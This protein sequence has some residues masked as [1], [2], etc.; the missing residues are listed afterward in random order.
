LKKLKAHAGCAILPAFFIIILSFLTSFYNYSFMIQIEVS[1]QHIQEYNL[2]YKEI[3]DYVDNAALPNIIKHCK[4]LSG[5]GSRVSGYLGSY[6]AAHYIFNTLKAYG[7]SDVHFESFNVTVPIDYGAEITVLQPV[8]VSFNAYTVWPNDVATGTTPPEGLVGRL[9]YGGEGYLTDFDGKDLNGSIVLMEFNSMHNWINAVKLGAKGI[10]FILPKETTGIE[11]ST[12]FADVPISIPRVVVRWNDGIYLRELAKQGNPIVKL[13]VKMVWEWRTIYNI[14]GTIPGTT[15][16]EEKMYILSNYDSMSYVPALSPGASEA[17]GVSALLEFASFIK[18]HPPKYTVIFIATGASNHALL[19]A[20]EYVYRHKKDL[21][22]SRIAID[23]HFDTG[24]NELSFTTTGLQG[25]SGLTTFHGWWSNPSPFGEDV[26]RRIFGESSY[27]ADRQI[28]PT[29]GYLRELEDEVGRFYHVYSFIGGEGK[30]YRYMGVGLAESDPFAWVNAVNSKLTIQTI[31]S[32]WLQYR[33]PTDTFEKLNFE[34][35]KPQIEVTFSMLKRLLDDDYWHTLP[36]QKPEGFTITTIRTLKYDREEGWYKPVPHAIVHAYPV[37]GTVR[38][39]AAEAPATPST[40]RIWGFEYYLIT[41]DNGEATIRCH[42]PK[43]PTVTWVA[44]PFIFKAYLINSTGHIIAATD[45]GRYGTQ[46]FPLS[47]ALEFSENYQNIILFECGSIVS[48]DLYDPEELRPYRED[49]SITPLQPQLTYAKGIRINVYDFNTHTEPESYSYAFDTLKGILWVAVPPNL[50]TEIIINTETDPYPVMFLI[51]ADEE[52]SSGMGY[53]VKKGDLLSIT[54]TPLIALKN[55]YLRINRIIET[56]RYHYIFTPTLNFYYEK[57]V[58]CY[59]KALEASNKKLYSISYVEAYKAWN[60]MKRAYFESRNLY[61]GVMQTAILTFI[62]IIPFAFLIERLI[63]NASGKKRILAT[64]LM[65]VIPF[66]V[67]FNIH[68]AFLLA[69]NTVMTVFATIILVLSIPLF[70]IFWAELS[71]LLKNLRKEI[72]GPHLA[73]ISRVGAIVMAFSYGIGQMRKHKF[74][75]ILNLAVITIITFSFVSIS[76]LQLVSKTSYSKIEMPSIRN[77]LLIEKQQ[78]F[79]ISPKIRLL[80][81]SQYPNETDILF[82]SWS[83]GET[84]WGFN[85][86]KIISQSGKTTQIKAILGLQ[87]EEMDTLRNWLLIEDGRFFVPREGN[88]ILLSNIIA[89]E[90]GVKT[91]DSVMLRG[92]NFTVVGIFNRDS[93]NAMIDL[94]GSQIT[95]IDPTDPTRT[96]HYSATFIAIIPF[97]TSLRLPIEAK[98]HQIVVNVQNPNIVW[99]LASSLA[100]LFHLEIYAQVNGETRHYS[101]RYVYTLLGWESMIVPYVLSLLIIVNTLINNVITRTRDISILNIVGLSP[102]HIA[103]MFFAESMVYA[104]I[105]SMLGYIAG[106]LGINI[107]Y[108]FQI[109]PA[110]FSANYASTTV[111]F[112]IALA[113][114]TTLGSTIYP[115]FKASRLVTP[116]LERSWKIPTKPY[117]NSWTIPLPFKSTKEECSGIFSFIHEYLDVFKAEGGPFLVKDLS[118]SKEDKTLKLDML[119]RLPPFEAGCDQKATL[120]AAWNEESSV[121]TFGVYLQRLSGDKRTWIKGNRIFINEL[122]KQFLTWRSLKDHRK[123]GL[124]QERSNEKK[125]K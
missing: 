100:K 11:A 34:N 5:L 16:P 3:V 80:I 114:I 99:D 10:I 57:A 64:V 15:Y 41:N 65:F 33:S 27:D 67:V 106:I 25:A 109:V 24:S 78:Y 44:P 94:D 9:I 91:G 102:L 18:S 95:P 52:H 12:K 82:R 89:E 58:Q 92:N 122:R 32:Y 66:V 72:I 87:P 51:N 17:L 30:I 123:N 113:T 50:D 28:K 74:T 76:S 90:L 53:K 2:S 39:E 107:Y 23:L 1:P 120:I 115:S 83:Y 45:F 37:A 61:T 79:S 47:N 70:F 38:P 116:S 108:S 26:N 29:G 96:I 105:G 103:A 62:L 55:I 59:M 97:D 93:L 6:L 68:P 98:I 117:G 85:P 21:E 111:I 60:Y 4:F 75:T 71:N 73:E 81:E 20:R 46:T 77:G 42:P 124:Y 88:A 43:R 101:Q 7:L 84:L 69:S 14:I 19:G 54:E 63:F 56:L 121:Y 48:Y 110:G 22:N 104:V 119:V 125:F 8:N 118:Y 35:L 86:I 112:A 40:R 49:T 36:K 13:K 31:N